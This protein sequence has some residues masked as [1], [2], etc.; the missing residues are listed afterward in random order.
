[1]AGEAKVV[2]FGSV[3]FGSI[4]FITRTITQTITQAIT[5]ASLT[6]NYANAYANHMDLRNSL[7]LLLTHSVTD[8]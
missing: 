1:M 6:Q 2:A 4:A 3:A 7:T 8:H 5:Q